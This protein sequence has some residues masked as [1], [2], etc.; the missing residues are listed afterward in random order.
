MKCAFHWFIVYKY[1]TMY[2]ANNIKTLYTNCCKSA[3]VHKKK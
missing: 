2:G 1:I 3:T